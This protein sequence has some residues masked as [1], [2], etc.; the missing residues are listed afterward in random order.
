MTTS[1]LARDPRS[2]IDSNANGH[3]GDLK[4]PRHTAP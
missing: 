3:G 4:S 1:D 2:G